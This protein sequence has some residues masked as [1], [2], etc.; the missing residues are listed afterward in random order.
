MSL[1][2][3]AAV[4]RRAPVRSWI[5]NSKS[6]GRGGRRDVASKRKTTDVAT[7]SFQSRATSSKEAFR[8]MPKPKTSK[9]DDDEEE[10]GDES[11]LLAAAAAWANVQQQEAVDGTPAV[12]EE[13]KE[14]QP[15]S[16]TYSVHITQINYDATERDIRQHFHK[17][18]IRDIRL[19]KS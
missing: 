19:V 11:D 16:T 1:Q 17:C 12:V 10:E 8:T 14:Q 9:R 13:Q 5:S 3:P 15:A 7:T 4:K 2:I 6:R 18:Q